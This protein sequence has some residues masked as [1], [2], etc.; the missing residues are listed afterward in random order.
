MIDLN[1]IY[2]FRMTHIRNIPHIL[3]FGITHQDSSN[4]NPN[5]IAIGD[6]SLISH[7]N[8]KS[9]P[10]GKYL[11]DYIPF[12]FG[13]R[14]PMLYVIQK[15]YNNV[16]IT[17]PKNI[18]YCVSNIKTI[19]DLNINFYFTDG[20]ATAAISRFY[21]I[22]QI[23]NIENILDFESINERDWTKSPDTKRKKEAEL[24]LEPDL[25]SKG[26]I[27]YAVYNEDAKKQLVDFGI[28]NNKIVI[29]PSFYF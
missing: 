19:L 20:H 17:P 24:L 4:K 1:K 5:Y 28:S 13:F 8:I 29:K 14:M 15:G 21:S 3:Q 2:L 7:R 26:M 27:G 11:G 18:V 10:N 25:P 23:S 9:L 12:Y 16:N 6:N 22:K